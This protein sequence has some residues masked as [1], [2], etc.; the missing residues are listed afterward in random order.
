MTADYR[1]LRISLAPIRQAFSIG[2]GAYPLDHA[3]DDALGD[4][5]GALH[6]RLIGGDGGKHFVLLFL[7][8]GEELR[9]ER[10]RQ[11]RAVAVERVG[12]EREPP[13]ELIGL[14]AVLD[15]RVV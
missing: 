15:A 6:L 8:V 9:V 13:G 3:L 14:L 5:G 10:L 11:L 7:L 4:D 12:F 2:A 1:L